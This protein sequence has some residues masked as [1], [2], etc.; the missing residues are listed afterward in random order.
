MV[1]HM[2][3]IV[4]VFDI[5]RQMTN[6]KYPVYQGVLIDILP[7]KQQGKPNDIH[8]MIELGH[9][10]I[11]DLKNSRK[12]NGRRFYTLPTIL[13]SAHVVPA[14]THREAK[15]S[16]V[17]YIN[18]YIDWDQYQELYDKDWIEKGKKKV[19]RIDRDYRQKKS[20][21]ERLEKAKSR[22]VATD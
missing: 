9:P 22:E 8:G 17:Y 4:T 12:L 13:R 20:K 18:N 16:D 21:Q 1:G 10:Y 14:F 19:D 2:Q 11:T 7:L 6:G 3:A 5:D 15:S